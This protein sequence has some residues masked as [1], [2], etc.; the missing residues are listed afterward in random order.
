MPKIYLYAEILSHIRQLTIYASLQNEKQEGTRIDVSSDK[1]LVTVV[2]DGESQSIYLPTQISGTAQVTFPLERKTEISARVQID[3]LNEWKDQQSTGIESP[4]TATDLSS[5]TSIQCKSCHAQILPAGKV[6][7]WKDLPSENWAELMD[8][9]F[10]HK[11]HDDAQTED[12]SAAQS[13]G[14]SAKSK[15]AI[16]QGIGMTDL[17][18]LVLHSEDCER[19]KVRLFHFLVHS[20]GNKKEVDLASLKH[21]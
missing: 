11:P 10:C 18:S 5:E 6:T 15:L 20:F 16:S 2:H 1:K 21:Q 17:S 3:D 4:W 12:D 13:K 7:T 14:F 9:W 8:F 19:V